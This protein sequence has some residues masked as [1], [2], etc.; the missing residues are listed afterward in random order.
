MRLFAFVLGKN[1]ELSLA[2][3]FSYFRTR[4]IKFKVMEIGDDFTILN[5]EYKADVNDFGGVIKIVEIK[6]VIEKLFFPEKINIEKLFS[7]EDKI[8]FGVSLYGGNNINLVEKTASKIKNSLK[9][10]N[11]QSNYMVSRERPFLTHVEVIKRNL[12]E[13]AIFL[14]GNNYYIGKSIGVHNPFEF[15]KRDVGRPQQRTMLSI[16]PRLCKI[17][18]NFL[19]LREGLVLDPF[20]GV[21]TI[22]QEAAL[23]GFRIKGMDIDR[24]CV[25]AARKNLEWLEKE[26]KIK[27]PEIDRTVLKGD[28]KNLTSYFSKHSVDGIV[29]EPYLG[30]PIKGTPSIAFA[31]NIL[32]RI[33][34]MYTAFFYQ[35]S[36][37]LKPN[38]RICII[39]PRFRTDKYTIGTDIFKLAK[40]YGFKKLDPMPLEI[41]HEYPYTDS[42]ERHKIIRE[43]NILQKVK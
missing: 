32:N 21:G 22:I 42:E 29:A 23:A 7:A 1:K 25:V 43:I 36:I 24:E 20:C 37:I 19:G 41:P 17:M 8:E 4:K 33:E 12:E 11:I 31:K 30:P 2:E 9:E 39:T 18:I 34:P 6:E 5:L 14:V 3:I 38:R 35:A 16:P 10:K 13:V 26:Y 27:I 40:R 28:V 15:Q